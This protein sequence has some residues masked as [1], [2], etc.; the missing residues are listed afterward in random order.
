MKRSGVVQAGFGCPFVFALVLIGCGDDGV[1]MG[2]ADADTQDAE[3]P[4]EDAAVRVE[5]G[6]DATVDVEPVIDASPDAPVPSGDTYFERLQARPDAV[7]AIA[8]SSMDEVSAHIARRATDVDFDPAQG[9]MRFTWPSSSGSN[10]DQAQVSIEPPI[11]TGNV[12]VTWEER[13]SGNW[14]A[15]GSRGSINGINTFK[16]F[17][18]SD[19]EAFQSGGLQLEIRKLHRRSGLTGDTVP[20][21]AAGFIDIRSYFGA[22]GGPGGSEQFQ[23]IQADMLLEVETWARYFLLIEYGGTGKVSLWVT[24]PGVAP[25]AI[26]LQAPGD[27]AGDPGAFR[28]FWFEHN[29]SQRYDGPT[30]H[31]WN[32]NFVVLD[33]VRDLAE[34]EMLV[35]EGVY[36]P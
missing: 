1:T 11:S 22:V 20:A 23:G 3:V 35:A 32:R 13:W 31:V 21:G 28:S 5:A 9:A 25:V 18:H 36:A 26:Y 7:V 17:Q 30:S 14:A 19:R 2:V 34:A 27:S 29:S 12:F 15:G 4:G 16:N 33:G 24:Q 10:V 8:F 6:V